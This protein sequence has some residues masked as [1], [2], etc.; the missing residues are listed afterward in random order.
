MPPPQIFSLDGHAFGLTLSGVQIIEH[1]PTDI[2]PIRWTWP[3]ATD[4]GDITFTIEYQGEF[5]IIRGMVIRLTD[6]VDNDILWSGVVTST[7]ESRGV[8]PW[9]RVTVTGTGWNFYLDNRVVDDWTSTAYT[10]FAIWDVLQYAG[11]VIAG[12]VGTDHF[13]DNINQGIVGGTATAQ[14]TSV[15]SAIDAI[16]DAAPNRELYNPQPY[17]VDNERVFHYEIQAS[18]LRKHAGIG[19]ATSIGDQGA[20]AP[21]YLNV[22]SGHENYKG[23]A[24]VYDTGGTALGIAG[25]YAGSGWELAPPSVDWTTEYGTGDWDQLVPS[26]LRRQYGSVSSITFSTIEDSSFRPHQ[27]ITLDDSALTGGTAWTLYIDSVSGTIDERNVIEV[28]V[29]I[30]ARS[31][32]I[33][34]TVASM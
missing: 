19:T 30:G 14:R 1:V 27:Q 29:A 21:E 11:V 28:E 9:R 18:E 25:A 13:T 15:R 7:D 17:F 20:L 12:A 3:S 24:Y 10:G 34:Q 23:F 5:S 6:N 33:V 4:N 31:R 8:G 26:G 2:A 16:L 32:S 22:S